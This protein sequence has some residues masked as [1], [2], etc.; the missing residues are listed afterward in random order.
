L[1]RSEGSTESGIFEA[2]GFG[3]W[4]GKPRIFAAVQIGLE[5]IAARCQ[6]DVKRVIRE[7]AAVA[8]SNISHSEVMED[9]ALEVTQ[10]APPKAA[11]AIAR[12]KHKR[13]AKE[14]GTIVT[15]SEFTL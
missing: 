7:L 13:C 3:D 8:F 6:V 1:Q 12:I 15:E 4:L 10:G 11:L 9:G 14:E 5:A 2:L